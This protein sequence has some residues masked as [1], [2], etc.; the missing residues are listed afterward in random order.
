MVG[1]PWLCGWE[2]DRHTVPTP[3]SRVYGKA[4]E[5]VERTALVAPL[6][7]VLRLAHLFSA[8]PDAKRVL[9]IFLSHLWTLTASSSVF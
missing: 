9:V 6:L 3:P 1:M 8:P 2:G 7:Q 5:T 4:T